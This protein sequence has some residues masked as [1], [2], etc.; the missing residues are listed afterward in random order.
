M[1][2]LDPILPNG[3]LIKA[4]FGNVF[5]DT[6]SAFLATFAGNIISNLL[7]IQ[8]TPLWADAIG[9]TSGCLTG[10]YLCKFITGRS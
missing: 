6:L 7:K 8:K 5:S 4:G 2:T 1:D 9:T 10:L 3:N